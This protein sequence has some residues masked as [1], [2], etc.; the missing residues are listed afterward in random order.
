MLKSRFSIYFGPFSLNYGTPSENK[1]VNGNAVDTQALIDTAIDNMFADLM[2]APITDVTLWLMHFPQTTSP[3]ANQPDLLTING[4][5]IV[6]T[7]TA[8][9][10]IWSLSPNLPQKIQALR[11]AGKNVVASM[12]GYDGSS[13]FQQI[14]KIGVDNFIQQ[15]ETQLFKPYHVNG[16]DIDLEAGSTISWYDAYKN[17][18]ATVV[19]LSN[20]LAAAGYVVTHAPAYDLST[21]F[22][23]DSCPGL[24]NDMP[25]LQATYN[26]K[27]QQ[28]A[29]KWLN[30]QFYAGG[31]PSSSQGAITGFETMVNKL[32]PQAANTGITN[33]QEFLLAGFWPKV[34]DPKYPSGTQPVEG[35]T[36]LN[37]PPTVVVNALNGLKAKYPSGYGGTFDWLY[38]Y[39]ISSQ[40]GYKSQLHDWNVMSGGL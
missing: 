13:T 25:I 9:G 38:Q 14:A 6:P 28:Q 40:Q 11:T 20:K 34:D 7:K 35:N 2:A 30:T 29:I 22:Y 24:P 27:V 15:L 39:F 36:P 23:T 26:A 19:E 17:N 3:F 5:P 32:A 31:D 8:G 21:S 12:G 37:Q 4:V 1:A 10:D 33:P 16:L 18:A